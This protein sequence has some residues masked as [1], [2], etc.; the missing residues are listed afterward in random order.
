[1]TATRPAT[2]ATIRRS[3]LRPG[4]HVFSVDVEEFFHAHALERAAPRSQWDALP[5]RVVESTERLI[6]LLARHEAHGTFF[7][8]GWVAQRHPAL[9]RR[10]AAAGTA[11]GTD[12]WRR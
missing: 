5:S 6:D 1:M 7:V 4:V 3:P 10:I 8:L 11:T 9:V 2:D 12:A